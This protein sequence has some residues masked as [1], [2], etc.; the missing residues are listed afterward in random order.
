MFPFFFF[1]FVVFKHNQPNYFAQ[2]SVNE[3]IFRESVLDLILHDSWLSGT[4]RSDRWL[5]SQMIASVCNRYNVYQVFDA[6]YFRCIFFFSYWKTK[7]LS[8]HLSYTLHTKR[9]REKT[10]L[11]ANKIWYCINWRS[12][13]HSL[14]KV[15]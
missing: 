7:Q 1:S 12:S 15:L 3:E 8:Y 9:R 2:V 6:K 11:M 5:L 4:I 13:D 10:Y 14:G